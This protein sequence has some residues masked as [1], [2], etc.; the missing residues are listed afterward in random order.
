MV[1]DRRDKEPEIAR[2]IGRFSYCSYAANIFCTVF[3]AYSGPG[4]MLIA[5]NLTKDEAIELTSKLNEQLNA[6]RR[7]FIEPNFIEREED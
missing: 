5:R 2:L 6:F 3:I 7:D 1:D 4:S